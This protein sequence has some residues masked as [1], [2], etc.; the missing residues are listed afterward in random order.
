VIAGSGPRAGHCRA[1]AGG[2]YE[3]LSTAKGIDVE[4]VHRTVIV[5]GASGNLGRAVAG[6]F[7]AEGANLVLVARHEAT[8]AEQFGGDGERRLFVAAD[9]GRQDDANGVAA[10][11][12][13]RFGRID[14]VCNLAGAFR[15][16]GPVHET[17][18][19]T[20][21]FLFD[22]NV[23][24][25]LCMARACVPAMLEAGGSIVNVAA[26]AALR[27]GANMGAYAAS[28]AAVMRLTEAMSAELR[29]RGINVNCV[30][31]TTIDTPQNRQAM[32]GADPARWVAPGDLARIIVFLASPAARAIHGASIPV[33]GLS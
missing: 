6:A 30:L 11:A 23:R 26:Y 33:S 3:A 24:S 10:A 7:A 18:D 25:V 32:P 2:V 19:A 9:L 13:A 17:S 27:A 4:S 16:D 8:L 21:Q 22:T 1:L 29:E 12:R 14:T 28:K 5:T 15:I 20:W 31:P